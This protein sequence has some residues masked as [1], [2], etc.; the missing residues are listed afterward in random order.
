MS[1]KEAREL[2][3][4]V[5]RTWKILDN[6]EGDSLYPTLRELARHLLETAMRCKLIVALRE[7]MDLSIEEE[8]KLIKSISA[9][10]A[11]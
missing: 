5:D 3:E 10:K 8:K 1:E 2:C 4:M 7:D 11:K 9:I 6:N